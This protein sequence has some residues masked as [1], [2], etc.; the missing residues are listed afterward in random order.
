M[1]ILYL[2][3]FFPE[4]RKEEI[5]SNSIGVV[6]SAG[7]TF[8]KAILNGLSL[9]IDSLKI[10]SSPMLGSYPARYKKLF[11]KGSTFEHLGFKECICSG[12]INL[13]LYKNLSRYQHVKKHI[14]HW[15][16]NN[17]GTKQVIVFTLDI[18]LLRA[19][20]EAKEKH[21]ELLICVIVTDLTRFYVVPDSLFSK[22]IMQYFEK[23]TLKYLS[24]INSFV[25]LTEYMK[26]D[27]MVGDR[28][29][30]VIE[31]IYN[32]SDTSRDLNYEKEP[33]KTI[34][35]TGTLARVFGIKHLL[36]AFSKIDDENYRL[37]ICGDGDS[38]DEII[39]RAKID[40]R[41]KYFG[42][43]KREEVLI[44]Q[45]RATV[46]INPRFSDSEYTLYSF[47]SKT[48]EYLASGTPTIMHPLKCL[49]KDYLKHLFI[50]Y[51]ESDLGLKNTIVDVCE[52][53]PK[54][55]EIFGKN[56]ADFIFKEKNANVQVSK[57]LKLIAIE[58]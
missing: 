8:Q 37:W 44:L 29:Y 6:Q 28:K 38:K 47:P 54:E 3:S 41:I 53:D 16:E 5:L 27:L 58:K 15:I 23:K 21:P 56:A 40:S 7:D 57:I 17:P 51:D 34:L 12:F 42:Q 31:G 4:S 43:L 24:R 35:Y 30:I 9:K 39:K 32:S 45:K 10:I 50:S 11:F 25:L 2:G 20:Y 26:Q 55:L 49:P 19:L 22:P 36:D 46:L 52:M 33:F 14:N 1:S 18:S 13:M 48:M